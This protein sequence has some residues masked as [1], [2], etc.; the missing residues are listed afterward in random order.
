L[1]DIKDVDAKRS[2][3]LVMNPYTKHEYRSE[4]VEEPQ[5]RR[6]AVKSVAFPSFGD[7]NAAGLDRN[8]LLNERMEESLRHE[9]IRKM[10]P[11]SHDEI[12]RI[13]VSYEKKDISPKT[14]CE[15]IALLIGDKN[16]LALGER[17]VNYFGRG[18][19]EEFRTYLKVYKKEV[20]FPPF[21]K[22]ETKRV[23]P[24]TKKEERPGFKILTLPKK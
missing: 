22:K 5:P 17:L 23:S 12:Q 18:V 10:Y 9:I 2:S 11:N 3:V 21:R 1:N 6:R 14:V 15:R 7:R 16:C 24:P 13:C 20:E 19:R 4:A 8:V